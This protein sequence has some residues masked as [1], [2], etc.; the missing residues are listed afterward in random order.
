MASIYKRLGICTVCRKRKAE[1]GKSQCF[2]C[3]EK[4]RL[5]KAAY[6]KEGKITNEYIA[7]EHRKAYQKRKEAGM[8]TRCG[9]KI[10][11]VGLVCTECYARRSRKQA[12]KYDGIARF[13]RPDYGLCYFCGEETLEG[14]SV[15]GKCYGRYLEMTKK[16]NEV[17]R[18]EQAK[19]RRAREMSGM[20]QNISGNDGHAEVLLGKM[21]EPIPKETQK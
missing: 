1:P 19:K 20:R 14:K 12:E 17:V 7:S 21:W 11:K 2:E 4:D 15:C 16:M 13:E 9:K 18:N 10:A 3:L 6:R 8:C 5:R